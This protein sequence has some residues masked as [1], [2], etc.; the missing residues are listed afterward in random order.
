MSRTSGQNEVLGQNAE[1]L[2]ER[3]ALIE[4]AG[5]L[6]DEKISDNV[7]GQSMPS[8]WKVY[9]KEG[10]A[11]EV[12]EHVA[13]THTTPNADELAEWLVEECEPMV[14][15]EARQE[16]EDNEAERYI[17]RYEAEYGVKYEG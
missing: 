13:K 12:A 11:L 1:G 2:T 3:E 4:K 8:V 6:A 10:F 14:Q 16:A 7:G 17:D 15:D 9:S 5:S